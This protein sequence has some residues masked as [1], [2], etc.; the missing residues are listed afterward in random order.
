MELLGEEEWVLAT[1]SKDQIEIG[2]QAQTLETK[3]IRDE[4]KSKRNVRRKL[5]AQNIK[6]KQMNEEF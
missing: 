4:I 6:N 3:E 5:A 1:M 2:K